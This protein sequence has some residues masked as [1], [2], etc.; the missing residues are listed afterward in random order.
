MDRFDQAAVSYAN[1]ILK[2]TPPR[3][4]VLH[5]PINNHAVYLTGRRSLFSIAFMAWVTDLAYKDAKEKFEPHLRRSPDA[6]N[7]ISKYKVDYAVVGQ[8]ERFRLSVNESFFTRYPMIGEAG[9]YKLYRTA[10]K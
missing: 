7:L 8:A 6:E 1:M 10:R 9:G 3:A 2:N 4:L 5:A